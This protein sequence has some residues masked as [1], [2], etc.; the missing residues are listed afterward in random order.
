MQRA[1]RRGWRLSG[2]DEERSEEGRKEQECRPTPHSDAARRDLIH[3]RRG[4]Q[5]MAERAMNSLNCKRCSASK[6]GESSQMKAKN[7]VAFTISRAWRD[8]GISL[9]PVQFFA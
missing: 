4:G 5:F 1:G 3:Q 8:F 6:D 7:R 9:D 2:G